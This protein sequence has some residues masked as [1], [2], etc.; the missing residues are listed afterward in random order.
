MVRVVRVRVWW[1]STVGFKKLFAVG[2]SGTH[3]YFKPRWLSSSC[4]YPNKNERPQNF[5][6]CSEKP[7]HVIFPTSL[8]FVVLSFMLHTSHLHIIRISNTL[9]KSI[10]TIHLLLGLPALGCKEREGKY[11]EAFSPKTTILRIPRYLSHEKLNGGWRKNK[12]LGAFKENSGCDTKWRVKNTN[13]PE[14]WAAD[15]E[16]YFQTTPRNP[17][18]DSNPRELWSTKSEKATE[19]TVLWICCWAPSSTAGHTRKRGCI[20]FA[21]DV[22][23]VSIAKRNW[24]LAL[25]P[26]STPARDLYPTPSCLRDT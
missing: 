26:E 21:D 18:Q 25:E 24:T 22:S 2:F 4:Q 23:Y 8:N 15:A 9:L 14:F 6:L 16:K 20:S 13:V 11:L 5:Q 10:S 17:Q 3:I 7:H 1:G 12:C 19:V